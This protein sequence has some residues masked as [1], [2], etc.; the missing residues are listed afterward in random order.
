[1]SVC[2]PRKHVEHSPLQSQN[3]LKN[4]VSS[5]N[6]EEKREIIAIISEMKWNG[7]KMEENSLKNKYQFHLK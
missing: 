4:V 1:M 2:E 7:H 6:R 5:I 3:Y